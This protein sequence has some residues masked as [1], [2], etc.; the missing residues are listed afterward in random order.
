MSSEDFEIAEYFRGLLDHGQQCD[1]PGCSACAAL[2]RIAADIRGRLF[3]S[4]PYTLQGSPLVEVH[5]PAEPVTTPSR[6]RRTHS[7]R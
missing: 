2:D 6:R 7:V 3:S 1:L 5:R 4:M